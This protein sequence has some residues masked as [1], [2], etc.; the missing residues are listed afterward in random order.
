MKILPSGDLN[1]K[2]VIHDIRKKNYR[3]MLWSFTAMSYAK[4]MLR[5]SQQE[6]QNG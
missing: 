3:F 2:G 6:V 4:K 1:R 5:F